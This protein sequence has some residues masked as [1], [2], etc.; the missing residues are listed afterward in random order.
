MTDPHRPSTCD[1]NP[2]TICLPEFRVFTSTTR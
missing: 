1:G 2:A